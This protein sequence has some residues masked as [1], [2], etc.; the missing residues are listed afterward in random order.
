MRE[1]VSKQLRDRGLR[2]QIEN[3]EVIVDNTD[4]ASLQKLIEAHSMIVNKFPSVTAIQPY[5][6]DCD[7]LSFKIESRS[8]VF[9]PQTGKVDYTDDR[10]QLSSKNKVFF[11]AATS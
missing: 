7:K 4:F 8:R 6:G 1:F 3:S 11:F 2:F 5:D 9:N 10:S